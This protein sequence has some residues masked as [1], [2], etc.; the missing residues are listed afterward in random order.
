MI[1]VLGC[2]CQLLSIST[3]VL[4]MALFGMFN[5]HQHGRLNASLVLLYAFT[6]WIAGLVSAHFYR[7]F[8]GVNWVANINITSALFTG[9][10]RIYFLLFIFLLFSRIER[11]F[12]RIQFD[13]H[14][15][16]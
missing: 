3:A 4:V 16:V 11:S 8:N 9:T 5:V 7:L 13:L 6:S 1:C 10:L 12:D 2:G 14:V 15:P